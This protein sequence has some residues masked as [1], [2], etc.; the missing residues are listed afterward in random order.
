M[1][2][3]GVTIK[4]FELVGTSL[5][6]LQRELRQ[7]G[8]RDRAGVSRDAFFGWHVKWR[9][10]VDGGRPRFQKTSVTYSAELIFPCAPHLEAPSDKERWHAFTTALSWHEMKHLRNLL[11]GVEEL[12]RAFQERAAPLTT[13]QAN[14]L[15]QSHLQRIREADISLDEATD[16]G[17]REGVTLKSS[18]GGDERIGKNK[19]FSGY[20]RN[21]NTN[22]TISR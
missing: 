14:E 16:H 18:A 7:K 19:S 9:W 10:P 1:K 8:P 3:S 11:V 22:L 17:R 2:H 12:R 20:S 4:L 21:T 15:G 5:D 13:Q 6:Q